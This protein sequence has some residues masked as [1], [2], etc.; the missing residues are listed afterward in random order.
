MLNPRCYLEDCI[1]FGL[2]DLWVTGM[3]WAAVNSAID[4]SFNYAV[5]EKAKTDFTK[6]TGHDWE[7]ALDSMSKNINC[8]R[9]FQALEVLW[10]T[11][12][13]NEKTSPRE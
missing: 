9:C 5:P 10:T 1:R 8:P 11:C 4:T 7:N 2:K 12:C 13:A 6:V 3:P